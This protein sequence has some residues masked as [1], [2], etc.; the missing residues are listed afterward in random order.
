MRSVQHLCLWNTLHYLAP[1]HGELAFDMQSE[2]D[3]YP[4]LQSSRED[5]IANTDAQGLR[6]NSLYTAPFIAM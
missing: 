3:F 6:N 2:L 4:C 5:M 1:L